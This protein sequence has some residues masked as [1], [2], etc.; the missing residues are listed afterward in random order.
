MIET[1]GE[2]TEP[3]EQPRGLGGTEAGAKHQ[4]RLRL[5][6]RTHG[7]TLLPVTCH[8]KVLPVRLREHDPVI[9]CD[10]LRGIG[11]RAVC[12]CGERGPARETVRQAREWTAAH[13]SAAAASG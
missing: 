7:R 2:V 9:G 13:L 11:Y 5:L 6:V 8:V 1:A 4:P 12:S 10:R 3:R